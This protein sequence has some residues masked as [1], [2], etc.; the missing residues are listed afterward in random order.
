METYQSYYTK[1]KTK[2]STELERLRVILEEEKQ[3]FEKRP[4]S[5]GFKIINDSSMN[6]RNIVIEDLLEKKNRHV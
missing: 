2:T 4:G 1:L 6:L 3:E 5:E